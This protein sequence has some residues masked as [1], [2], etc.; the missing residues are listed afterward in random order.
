[1]SFC[2]LDE[3]DALLAKRSEVKNAHDLYANAETDYLLKQIEEYP[4]P[5]ILTTNPQLNMDERFVW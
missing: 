1:V 4:G 2:F 5:V 3:A